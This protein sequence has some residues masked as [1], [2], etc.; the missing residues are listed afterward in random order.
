MFCANLTFLSIPRLCAEGLS[1]KGHAAVK[2]T[3]AKL[4]SV[5]VLE[6]IKLLQPSEYSPSGSETY[7]FKWWFLET[8]KGLLVAC[9]EKKY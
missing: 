2:G 4:H 7:L 9:M 1:R 5:P 3:A 8:F 6:P